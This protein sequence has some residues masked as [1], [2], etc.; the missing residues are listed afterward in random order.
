MTRILIQEN[1]NLLF[2]I[3]SDLKQYLPHLDQVKKS[4][5]NLQLGNFSNEILKEIIK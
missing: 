3:S 2:E 4:Y 5:E 1:K